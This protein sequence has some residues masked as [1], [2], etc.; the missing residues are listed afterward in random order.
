M[1]TS[2]NSRLLLI[3]HQGYSGHWPGQARATPT[4]RGDSISHVPSVKSLHMT[5]VLLQQ[6]CPG[7]SATHCPCNT[8][9]LGAGLATALGGLAGMVTMSSASCWGHCQG[10]DWEKEIG[11]YLTSNSPARQN[12]GRAQ[13][14]RVPGADQWCPGSVNQTQSHSTYQ[15]TALTLSVLLF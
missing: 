9:L 4:G 7:C 3:L 13:Q 11:A 1:P 5:P 12:K 15:Q 8:I 2:Q 10:W 14:H 6:Q